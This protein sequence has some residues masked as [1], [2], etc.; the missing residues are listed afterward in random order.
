MV[1]SA[2]IMPLLTE[3]GAHYAEGSLWSPLA[4]LSYRPFFAHLWHSSCLCS[5]SCISDTGNRCYSFLVP[6]TNFLSISVFP[7]NIYTTLPDWLQSQK[8]RKVRNRGQLMAMYD[9]KIEHCFISS[10]YP[11]Y[12]KAPSI[13]KGGI[14]I[15]VLRRVA[16]YK[17][18]RIVVSDHIRKSSV[19]AF[20]CQDEHWWKETGKRVEQKDPLGTHNNMNWSSLIMGQTLQKCWSWWK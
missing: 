6:E 16:H 4:W 13:S 10:Y 18:R 19:S 11:F 17:W 14:T 2:P 5:L 7:S 9:I 1:K 15:P 20:W 12:C 8:P 3:I